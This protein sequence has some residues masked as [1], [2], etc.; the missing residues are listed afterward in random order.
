MSTFRGRR[1]S[2]YASASKGRFVNHQWHCD[3]NLPA[4]HFQV[5]KEGANKGRWF[6][7]CQKQSTDESRCRFFL[8]DDEAKP[9]EQRVLHSNSRSELERPRN[10]MPANPQRDSPPPYTVEAS[11]SERPGK[12]S[13]TI[14]EQDDDEF[15]MGPAD[16]GELGPIMAAAETPRKAARID[17]FTTPASRNLPWARGD[18]SLNDVPT[19]QTE[20][21]HTDLFPTKFSVP[22][23]SLLTPSKFKHSEGSRTGALTPTSSFETPTPTRFKDVGLDGSESGLARAVF[24]LLHD[25]RVDVSSE[26][27]ET[28]SKLLSK[29]MEGNKNTSDFLRKTVKAKEARITE[30]QHRVST[31]EAE[32]EAEKALSLMKLCPFEVCKA[33]S[34]RPTELETTRSECFQ[35]P[36]HRF[37]W[38]Q[39]DDA[40]NLLHDWSLSSRYSVEVRKRLP[41]RAGNKASIHRELGVARRQS[42]KAADLAGAFPSAFIILS[43]PSLDG[44]ADSAVRYTRTP[45]SSA[46]LPPAASNIKTPSRRLRPAWFRYMALWLVMQAR[47][48]ANK[49]EAYPC[50]ASS[51]PDSQPAVN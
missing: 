19:P 1:R 13:R 38:K 17:A 26:T 9:R 11:P 28:L 18:N 36:A 15:G 30:L 24:N 29:H 42:G 44:S 20:Q 27:K 16:S 33:H 45:I 32:L 46:V 4:V 37:E 10:T 35:T 12:R 39:K 14:A 34:R 51:S 22:G 31:L 3:C 48:A 40:S 23:G 21:H 7:S 8:W 6:Y 47:G 50:Q 49:R 25:E 43:N 5:K 41:N 2:S